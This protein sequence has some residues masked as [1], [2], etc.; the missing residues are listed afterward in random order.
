MTGGHTVAAFDAELAR[1]HQIIVIM[2]RRVEEQFA[3]ALQAIAER[4]AGKAARVIE[5]DAEIDRLELELE[6][7]SVRLLALRQPVAKDLRD[8]VSALKIASNLERMGDFAGS[9]AKRA[10]TLAGLPVEPPVA[11]LSWMGETV[12]GMIRD[13]VAAYDVQDAERAMAVR[14]RDGQVDAA[15]TSLF[16]EFL[17]YMM[18]SPAQITG[19]THL[20][21][22]AKSIERAGDHATNVAE[23]ICYIVQ[24]RLP[25]EER[26]KGDL[27]SFTVVEKE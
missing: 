5:G 26:A 20:L 21:F 12:L 24:G 17:T 7:L 16:R 25:S 6:A 23:N 10:V 19:C 15:Y 8:I 18:E 27:S 1:L 22:V 13:V 9:V 11:S 14:N 2:G 4:D 3:A